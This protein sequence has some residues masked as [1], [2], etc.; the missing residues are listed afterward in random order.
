MVFLG[1]KGRD[2]YFFLT[3]HCTAANEPRKDEKLQGE[4]YDLSSNLFLP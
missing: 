3:L 2:D 1:F 4:T